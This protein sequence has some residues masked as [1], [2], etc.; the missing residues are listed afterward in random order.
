MEAKIRFS[1]HFFRY[2]FLLRFGIGFSW[3][4]GGSKPEKSVKTMVFSMVFAN[5]QK[6]DVFEKAAKKLKF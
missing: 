2:F 4:L 6:I 5:F 1:R 3:I